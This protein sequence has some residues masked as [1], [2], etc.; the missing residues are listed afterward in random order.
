MLRNVLAGQTLRNEEA[1]LGIGEKLTLTR[2]FDLGELIV[3]YPFLGS[4]GL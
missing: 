3:C 2:V 4:F 1:L